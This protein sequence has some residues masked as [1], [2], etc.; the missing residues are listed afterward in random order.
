MHLCLSLGGRLA[1]SQNLG[2]GLGHFAFQLIKFLLYDVLIVGKVRFQPLEC[3]GVV[4]SLEILLKLIQLLV[5]HLVGQ[6]DTDTHFERLVNVL[7][8]AVLLGGRQSAQ[9][10]FFK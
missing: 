3:T 1:G 6:P 4:L 7:K 2:R 10:D 5:G 9:A 8:E